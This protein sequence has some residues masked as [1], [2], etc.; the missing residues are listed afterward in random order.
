MKIYHNNIEILDI[1]VDDS[2]YR[3]R[4]IKGDHNITLY[5]S[6]A[7]HVE[8]PVGSYCVYQNEIYTLE[9]PESLKMKHSRYFEYTVI[10]DSPQ[11]KSKR[12]KFRN[13]VDGRLKFSLTAKPIEHLQMFVDNMNQRDSGWS[14]GHCVDSAEITLSY[15]HVFCN[16][17]LTQMADELETEYEFVGKQV[18][19][20]KVE[21]NKNNPLP[22]S[23]GRGNGF[24]PDVGRS[25]YEDKI[26]IEILYTQGS[27][28]NIDPSKYGSSELLLPK[29]QQIR[30]DGVHFEDE[31][32]FDSSKARTYMTDAYGYSVRR[33]DKQ[34]SSLAEDSL[35]CSGIYPSRVG[36]VSEVVVVDADKNFYDIIDSGIPAALNF[37]DCLIEGE[38]MTV[39]FQSGMLA[40]RELEVKYIHE[41]KG[42]K[43][44]RRFEIVPQEI[45]GVTMPGG[46]Y[47]PRVS[48]KYAVFNCMLPDAYICD[49]A[50]KSG[51]SWD[52]FRE[53]VKN[54]Y[55]NE[56]QKFSFTG[57]LDGIWAKQDWVN[58]GGRIKLG[59]FVQFT[60]ERFQHEGVLVRIIGIKDYINNP[61]SPEIELSNSTV[62]KNVSSQLQQIESNEV[63]MEDLHKEAIQFT[64]RRYRDA[65]ETIEM[66]GEALLDNFTNSIN[67]ITVQTMAM[68]VG[69]ESL[70]FQFVNNTT[71]P[72]P[73]AHN[74][75]YNPTTKVL[76]V[77][78]GIIQHLT[79]GIDSISSSHTANEY[80]YWALA[81]FETPTLTDGD[82]KYYLYAKVSKTAQTGVFYIS[83]TA[84]GIEDVS[85]Y[86]HLL[87]GVLNSEF[88]DVRS[89]AS[90]YGFT[91]VMPGR[92]TTDKIV[93]STGNSFFDMLN[94]AMK[95]G[96]VFDFNSQGDG[97]LRIKGT[98]VQS[99]S[100]D[101]SP[102]G[103][104]RGMY[105]AN[106]T[107]YNGDE[108]A[109]TQN[110]LTSTYRFIYA[111]PTK[112]ID[113]TNATHWQ[114]R[115]A[116]VK[117]DKGDVGSQGIPGLQGLQGE[118]GEQ[119]IQGE[120]GS[121]G[122]TSY[123]H[124]KYAPVQNPTAEQMTE[125]PSYYVGTY[126]DFTQTDSTDPL[127]YTWARFQGFDGEQGIPGIN[128]EDGET[129]YL[130]IKYSNDGG[131]T[132]SSKVGLR[133]VAFNSLRLTSA[134]A[135]RFADDNIG[136]VPGAYIGQYVDNIQADSTDVF[137]YTWTKIKGEQS[138]FHVKYSDYSDGTNMNE[139]GGK[140]IGTYVD[141]TEA[142]STDKTKYTWV[143]VKGAQGDKGDQGIAGING[144]NGE[145]SYLHIAYAD[146]ADG[147]TNFSVSDSTSKLYIGQYTDFEQTDSSDPSHY[148]WTKIKGDVGDFYEYR[149]AKNGSTTTPPNIDTVALNPD[150]WN[151]AV[152]PVG[153]LEYLWTTMAK[154]S[155]DG[156]TLLQ[157]W[158]TPVRIT[159]KDGDKGD[160]GESPA[161]VFR[162]IYDSQATYYG[163]NYRVDAVKYNGAYYVARIDAG[164]FYGTVP[165]SA[166]KWNS[167]G[168]QFESVATNLLLAE[169]AN[170]GDW[171]IKGGKITSQ[172]TTTD[173]T[174]NA[175]M[176][177]VNGGIKFASD[178]SK[179]T[180]SRG[181]ETKKQTINISSSDGEIEVRTVDYDIAS[182]SSQG[183]FANRAGTDASAASTGC[184]LKGAIV[185]LGY[186]KM[187]KSMWGS[188]F[189]IAGVIGIADNSSANPAPAYGGYFRN[190]LA[191]GMILN[192]LYISGS[193]NLTK[194]LSSAASF[195]LSFATAGTQTIY[196]PPDPYEGQIIFLKQLNGGTMQVY[197]YPGQKL[198]DDSSENTYYDAGEGQSLIAVCFVSVVNSISYVSWAVNRI[199]F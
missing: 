163:N 49:N 62:G 106:Y 119:G 182:I 78:S 26:P 126:V 36:T 90:L 125:T 12:F 28:Q 70:Q 63:L 76:S 123:F 187:D 118:Q 155:G 59:G 190:L 132:F 129:S 174:P 162:G 14:V 186:G 151:T 6:L 127:Q 65:K 141:Y 5:F 167:F 135:F 144:E 111:T 115:A 32:G 8:I 107:Y 66:L 24:K 142:D 72:T 179:Y 196:L 103:V 84:I 98:I 29:S 198:Y 39:T 18:S 173:G 34:L 77:P 80:K 56:D 147:Q 154:K 73:V 175:Q 53:A 96:D 176:D 20:G 122:R 19:L 105:N 152:P 1:A 16:E 75:V 38:T 189:G 197:P 185:G 140:Y 159:P 60:D 86:Y 17:A 2:S 116:G 160:K 43:S 61:H 31:E 188:N 74:V 138:Y 23:Y 133:L 145:T 143:L 171:I 27:D 22:L 37:E 157:N 124:I 110:G 134:T 11:A 88:E 165:T 15:N 149:Y 7:Q 148:T 101:E 48:D 68:L 192:P 164:T 87:M 94:E 51:A 41:A 114:V 181:T 170:I 25:N 104:Y 95:L 79:L 97:K 9:K 92:I 45:D 83:E 67:P 184:S 10:F 93:S 137:R 117:G 100:G 58:I 130:H 156:T 108:V 46:V 139:T 193:T 13:P 81:A 85:G 3:Y 169:N 4:A 113:P 146:S 40:G 131:Q 183:I 194:Y 191:A 158:S 112:G 50:T 52:M 57:A 54:L 180:E 30:F 136:E 161:L 121:N 150:G 102:I 99:E 69:D 44:A 168:A 55:D 91:E 128:G 153:S 35:D 64:K 166:T 195:I 71:N 47:I 199:K 109:F 120:A 21:Y 178:V 82:K 42:G 33:A 89:Y 172:N 177:G